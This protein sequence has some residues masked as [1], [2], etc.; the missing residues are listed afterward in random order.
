MASHAPQPHHEIQDM[1]KWALFH[2]LFDAGH[3]LHELELPVFTFGAYRFQMTKFMVLEVVA[4]VLILLIFIPLA[5]RIQTGGLP[6]G[7]FWN[8]FEAM[9]LFV[10]DQIARPNIGG[11]SEHA[12]DGHGDDDHG[13]AKVHPADKYVPFLWTLFLFVLFLNLFGMIP[14]LGSPTASIWVTGGMAL[15]SFVMMHAVVIAQYG[16]KRY[17]QSLWPRVDMPPGAA[18]QIMG[19]GLTVLL[20]LIEFMG[21]FIKG[22]VLAVRLFAN[23]FAGHL[24]LANILF[25]IYVA[26]KST[27]VLWGAV[28]LASVL[29]VVA[30][31]LLELFV[32]LLQAYIFTFLTALFMGMQLHHAEAH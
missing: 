4:A 23:M 22:G 14:L 18:S 1:E 29:G 27:V 17:W 24:V 12:H 19:F 15:I 9:L 5:R 2:N 28:T 8:F 7:R 21:T 25:F 31:S 13:H 10:R 32:G 16:V 30:L 6:R 3:P 26:A 11:H 20:G